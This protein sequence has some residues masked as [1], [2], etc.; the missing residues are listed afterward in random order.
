MNDQSFLKLKSL[1]VIWKKQKKT[2]NRTFD[3]TIYTFDICYSLGRHGIT[4]TFFTSTCENIVGLLWQWQ[5]DNEGLFWRCAVPLPQFSSHSILNECRWL[6]E[7]ELIPKFL[8]IRP[9]GRI[10]SARSVSEHARP[11]EMSPR[12][13]MCWAIGGKQGL[14]IIS[15]SSLASVQ[16]KC[17]LVPAGGVW[18]GSRTRWQSKQQS[19]A[20][21]K[22]FTSKDASHQR[23]L[24]TSAFMVNNTSLAH[25]SHFLSY[26]SPSPFSTLM[27]TSGPTR[28]REL[29]ST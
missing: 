16:T 15:N 19:G 5:R 26:F 8:I 3:K 28:W 18:A 13:A 22:S 29:K 14:L 2:A 12:G 23:R 17:H 11:N 24:Q 25:S 6:G 27:C 10:R 7:P 9:A 1:I 20:R 4:G 21:E